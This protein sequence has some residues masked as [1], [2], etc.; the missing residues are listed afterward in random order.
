MEVLLPV[1]FYFRINALIAMV[2]MVLNS[3]LTE[4]LIPLVVKFAQ[5][6]M[7]LSIKLN[8]VIL[9]ALWDPF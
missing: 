1:K 9:A 8:L 5:S 6:L 4:E 3:L 2:P 7:W